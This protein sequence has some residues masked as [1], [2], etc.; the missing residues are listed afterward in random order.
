[1]SDMNN[2]QMTGIRMVAESTVTVTETAQGFEVRK[3][4]KL[5]GITKTREGAREL[6]TW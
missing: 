4:G 1:M 3:G 6:A 2:A 5:L